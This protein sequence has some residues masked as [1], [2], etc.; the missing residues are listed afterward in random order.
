MIIAIVGRMGSGKTL[1]MSF[2]AKCQHDRGVD[3]VTNY[4][5]TFPHRIITKKD[6]IS[7]T[8]GQGQ[9]EDCALLIDEAQ[10]MLDCRS[11]HKNQIISYFLLQSRKRSVH[12]YYSTQ[13]FF[14]VEKRLRE[15]TDYI[16]QCEAIKSPS[17]NDKSKDRLKGIKFE[18]SRYEGRNTFTPIRTGVLPRPGRY[19]ALY[20]TYQIIDINQD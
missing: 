9:L 3:I 6:I 10:I 16:I 18:I 5:L 15:N 7:Y 14:N 4:R 13:Q 12:I 20:N 19:Y 8:Q 2:L 11:H 17:E 1:L